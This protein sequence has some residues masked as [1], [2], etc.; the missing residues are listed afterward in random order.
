MQDVFSFKDKVILITGAGRGIGKAITKGFLERGAI[1]YGTGSKQESADLINAAGANGRVADVTDPA[2]MPTLIDEIVQK[3]TRIDCLINNSGVSSDTPASF[4]KED[5]IEKIL[6]TNVKGVFRSCQAYFK[7]H[8]KHGGTIINVA[9]VL[10]FVGIPLAS[11]YCASK[12]GVIQLTKALAIEWASYNFRVNALCPGLIDTDMTSRMTGKPD[13]LNKVTA[14]IP[15]K[16]LGQ[17]EDLV[18]AA[19]FMASSASSYM[20]GQTLVIDGGMIAQ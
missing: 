10:G 11:I 6:N 12:G 18:G 15:L 7:T 20:T 4:F 2:A 13:L 3:H 16:R 17:P 1:V 14:S 5:E 19:L 8:R 9:S